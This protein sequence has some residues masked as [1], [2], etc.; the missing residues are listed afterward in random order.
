MRQL[1]PLRRFCFLQGCRVVANQTTRSGNIC[2]KNVLK[3]HS[4][5]EMVA[6]YDVSRQHANTSKDQNIVQ[7]QVLPFCLHWFLFAWAT[8]GCVHDSCWCACM[9]AVLS[10]VCT[11][12]DILPCMSSCRNSSVSLCMGQ[13][14]ACWEVM[15]MHR[16]QKTNQNLRVTIKFVFFL[17]ELKLQHRCITQKLL[18]WLRNSSL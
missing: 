15:E 18:N 10:W 14:S 2:A 3:T 5:P 4:K 6:E 16:C 1:Q 7:G 13:L 8:K 12:I 9:C 11:C 17:S